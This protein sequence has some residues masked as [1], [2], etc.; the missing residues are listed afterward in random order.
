MKEAQEAAILAEF[1]EDAFDAFNAGLRVCWAML[2]QEISPER[3]LMVLAVEDAADLMTAELANYATQPAECIDGLSR[4]TFAR[5]LHKR[6]HWVYEVLWSLIPEPGDF[7][8]PQG[9]R[10][11][12]GRHQVE[13]GSACAA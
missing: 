6:E 13:N 12:R 2:P 7:P 8:S 9:W 10:L 4:S 3:R 1:I 11:R 5:K